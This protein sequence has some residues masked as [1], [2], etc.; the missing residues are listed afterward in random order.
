MA[1]DA[2]AKSPPSWLVPLLDRLDRVLGALERDA[3]PARADGW[4]SAAELA[5]HIGVSE[6]SIR[7]WEL[8]GKLPR[9]ARVGRLKK[10]NRAEVE[11]HLSKTAR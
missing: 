5:G 9:P 4:M 11:R 8:T 7:T 1:S 3:A 10:W 6:R 2:V